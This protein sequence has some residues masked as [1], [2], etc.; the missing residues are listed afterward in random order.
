LGIALK[1]GRKHFR[2]VGREHQ[3]QRNHAGE[4][5]VDLKSGLKPQ[6]YGDF[7]DCDLQSEIDHEDRQ[8]FGKAAKNGGV[9]I[10]RKPER[11]DLALLGKRDEEADGQ[12]DGKCG[13]RQHAGDEEAGRDLV[14][15][16]GIAA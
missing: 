3:R 14:A 7:P 12:A 10:G 16:A 1:A 9:D 8:Q 13:Q 4:E 5:G 6:R 2:G 15:P 11:P